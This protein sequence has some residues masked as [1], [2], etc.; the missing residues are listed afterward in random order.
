M[1]QNVYSSIAQKRERKDQNNLNVKKPKCIYDYYCPC[2]NTLCA[3]H[4]NHKGV[5]KFPE[6]QLTGK[7][8]LQQN[9]VQ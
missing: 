7:K 3:H 6:S 4:R 8:M 9:I 5:T 2:L 1:S